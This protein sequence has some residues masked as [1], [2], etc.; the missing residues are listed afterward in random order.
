MDSLF[1]TL[2]HYLP[3]IKGVMTGKWMAAFDGQTYALWEVGR[4]FSQ[5]PIL[6]RTISL[7]RTAPVCQDALVGHI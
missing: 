4:Q 7:A 3:V 1:G 6:A 2:L 5:R